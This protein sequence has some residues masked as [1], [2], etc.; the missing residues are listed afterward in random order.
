MIEIIKYIIIF[1][2]IIIA[3]RHFMS[4]ILVWNINKRIKAINDIL[5]LKKFCKKDEFIDYINEKNLKQEID[6]FISFLN[7]VEKTNTSYISKLIF[8]HVDFYNKKRK[9]IELSSSIN[10]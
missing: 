2:I 8:K 7:K 1:V 10:Y 4:I 3:K 5:K 6:K 9:F